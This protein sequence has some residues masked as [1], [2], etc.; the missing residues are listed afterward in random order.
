MEEALSNM[1]PAERGRAAKD[2]TKGLDSLTRLPVSPGWAIVISVVLGIVV[3]AVVVAL[4]VWL[5][6]VLL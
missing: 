5:L 2:I 4:L 1:P 6:T 3:A